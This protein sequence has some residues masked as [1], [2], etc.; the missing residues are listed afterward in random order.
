MSRADLLVSVIMPLHGDDAIVGDV[1]RDT[2]TVLAENYTHHEIILVADGADEKTLSAAQSAMRSTPGVRLILLSRDFGREMSVLAGLETSIGDYVVILIPETDP[3][4]LIPQMV[5]QC[6]ELDGMVN[7]VDARGA[8]GGPFRKILKSIFHAYMR[9]FL[10]TELLPGCTDFRVLSRR[11]VNALTQFRE[12][13]RQ[14]TGSS[15][16]AR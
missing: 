2:S 15:Y 16:W 1:V 13:Y 7:G 4:S 8:S 12:S 14:A 9:R 5:A 11:M 3:P 6:R 10:K